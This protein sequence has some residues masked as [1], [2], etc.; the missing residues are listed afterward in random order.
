M[1]DLPL[2]AFS[3]LPPPFKG[4]GLRGWSLCFEK[5][6]LSEKVWEG[7]NF[8]PKIL[9]L[10]DAKLKSYL[11]IPKRFGQHCS[12]IVFK[13]TEGSKLIEKYEICSRHWM[14]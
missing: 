11:L 1:Y 7:L 12:M 5:Q 2:P 14:Q 10:V 13:V 8:K 4:G 9:L 6:S 3:G